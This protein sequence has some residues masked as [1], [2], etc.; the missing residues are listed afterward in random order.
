MNALSVGR[1]GVDRRQSTDFAQLVESRQSVGASLSFGADEVH[2]G[3]TRDD[4]RVLAR[5]SAGILVEE[6][7]SGYAGEGDLLALVLVREDRQQ[8]FGGIVDPLAFVLMSIGVEQVADVEPRLLR[9][10]LEGEDDLRVGCLAE[11]LFE[12]V[13]FYTCRSGFR[14]VRRPLFSCLGSASRVP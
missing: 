6:G 10:I 11:D 8:V 3:D 13:E 9:E 7:L 5:L 12:I 14:P 1:G 2:L 4:Y